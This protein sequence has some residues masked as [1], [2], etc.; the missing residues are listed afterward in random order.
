MGI[1]IAFAGIACGKIQTK[2][3]EAQD[4]A[5]EFEWNVTI[6]KGVQ[7]SDSLKGVNV[8][9]FYT[10]ADTAAINKKLMEIKPENLTFEWFICDEPYYGSDELFTLV[11]YENTP[12]ISENVTVT[13]EWSTYEDNVIDVRF[14]FSD[15]DKWAAITRENRGNPLALFV[16]GHFICAPIVQDVIEYGNCSVLIPK[17][18][19]QD[20]LPNLDL[21]KL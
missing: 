11:A 20:Y 9:R 21:K 12:L 13:P 16:N 4:E 3:S 14:H 7:L 10:A 8:N 2:D 1:A 18:R 17:H 15:A 6:R 19:V 5:Q